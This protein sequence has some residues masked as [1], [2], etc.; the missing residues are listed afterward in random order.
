MSAIALAA[1][2]TC[3][4]NKYNRVA[5]WSIAWLANNKR[6]GESSIVAGWRRQTLPCRSTD[7]QTAAM[8]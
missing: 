4:R 2:V 5:T 6:N 8:G 1:A 3:G 7:P